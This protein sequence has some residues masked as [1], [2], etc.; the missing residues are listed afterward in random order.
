MRFGEWGGE[1]TRRICAPRLHMSALGACV[2]LCLECSDKDV[3]VVPGLHRYVALRVKR[4]KLIQLMVEV[5]ESSVVG[6]SMKKLRM[7]IA[8]V[9]TEGN[10]RW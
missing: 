1:K 4:R 7:Q 8:S 3:M 5:M 6:R 2:I 10:R 9:E